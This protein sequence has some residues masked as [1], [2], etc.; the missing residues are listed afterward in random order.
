MGPF[1]WIIVKRN[2]GVTEWRVEERRI[3]GLH[4]DVASRGLLAAFN[5]AWAALGHCRLNW[6]IRIDEARPVADQKSQ[7]TNPGIRSSNLFGRANPIKHLLELLHQVT[8]SSV[9]Q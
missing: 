5:Y 8:P 2:Q 3:R 7:T 1:A 6:A 4:P 9:V